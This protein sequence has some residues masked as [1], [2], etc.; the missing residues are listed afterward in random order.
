[1][2]CSGFIQP[3]DLQCIFVNVFAGNN[4]TFGLLLAIVIV[5]ISAY[6][7]MFQAALGTMILVAGFLFYDQAPWMYYISLFIAAIMF[8]TQITKL[9]KN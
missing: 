3:G 6:F 9:V 4:L 2:V 8:I 1:M 7:K 5:G